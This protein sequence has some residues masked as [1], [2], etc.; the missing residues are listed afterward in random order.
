M[1][2]ALLRRASAW[3][4]EAMSIRRP[5]SDTAPLPSRATRHKAR[6]AAGDHHARQRIVPRVVP[7]ELARLVAVLVREDAV[8]RMRRTD[9]HGARAGGGCVGGDAEAR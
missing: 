8:I 4:I 5:P 7:V 2:A 3:R 6:G 1:A 9:A